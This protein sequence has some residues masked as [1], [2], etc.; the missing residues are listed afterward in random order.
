MRV[1]DTCAE[2]LFDKQRHLKKDPAYLEEVRQILESRREEDTSPYLVYLFQ[3]AR[4]RRFGK[5]SPYGDIKR[6]YNALVLSMEEG[7]RKKIQ[8]SPDPLAAALVL[9][10]IGN[11]IDFGAMTHVDRD[12]FLSLFDDLALSPHDEETLKSFR[13]EC[14]LAGNFLLI[15]DNCGEIILD[16]LFLEELKKEFPHLSLTVM[17]RG[18]EI[19]NDATKEDA[20]YAGMDKV[21]EIVTN[22]G[23]VAGTVRSMLPEEAGK[24]LDRA[25][26]ILAKGQGNYESLSGQGRHVFYSFLCKCSLFTARFSVP[27]LTGMFVEETQSGRII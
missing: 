25:D 11:Y 3:K 22:G 1:I 21:A 24:A 17:V 26:V 4:E 7:L 12:T 2:C 27:P 13:R 14:R 19:L 18:E 23:P 16:R 8:A 15:C 9:A 10:R 5:E 20:L 6:E